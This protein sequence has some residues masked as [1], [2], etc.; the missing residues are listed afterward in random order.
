MNFFSLGALGFLVGL[1]G[2]MLPGP[3]SA[4]AIASVL[5]G[6]FRNVISIV[7]GHIL[8]EA[9]MVALILLG[10]KPFLASETV[11]NSVSIVGAAA[12]IAIGLR[13]IFT[14]KRL[15]L[16]TNK[17]SI[18]ASRLILGG[19]FFT[20]FNPTFPIWWISIGASLIS[21]AL[22]L[23]LLGVIVLLAGHWLADLAWFSFVGLAVHKGK[24][25]LDD[26]RYQLMLKILALVLIGL[27]IW[28]IWQVCQSQ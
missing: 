28:F 21:R 20:A 26:R 18:F 3:M 12:L 10:L 13:I 4:Y 16:S 19:A 22:L 27:G 5:Q 9:A 24:F 6:R 7:L 8:I 25:Y 14:A 15:K 1:T 17:D 2:A 11:F 23:G